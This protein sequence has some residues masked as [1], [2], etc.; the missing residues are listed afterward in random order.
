[1]NPRHDTEFF[2]QILDYLRQTR[3][4]DFTAYKRTSLMR[5]VLKRMQTVGVTSFE[6]YLD[7]L[8]VHQEEFAVLFNTILINVTSFFRDPEVWDYVDSTLVPMILQTRD[9]SEPLRVWSAGSA[10]GQEAYTMAMLL[11]ERLGIDGFRE[12]VKIYATDVDEEA[13]TQARQA[14]YQPRQ[15]EDVPQFLLEKYFDQVGADYAFSRDLRRAVIFGRH[16]L[17]QDA[18][19]S[20]VDVVLCRNTL[21]YFNSEAQSKILANLYFSVNPGGFLILGRA[22]MLFSHAAMFASVDLKRRVF[23]AVPKPNQRERLLILAQTGRDAM[24]SQTPDSFR[25]RDAAF[26]TDVIPQIVLDPNGIVVAV[27]LPV[28]QQFGIGEIDVGRP[29]QDLD[30]SYRPAELRAALRRALEE[31]REVMLKDIQWSTNGEVR[32]YDVAVAPLYE[33]DRSVLG[34]RITFADVTKFRTLQNELQHS[35]QELETAY[36]EL[37]STNE[38]LETTNEELQ[39]TVEELE[40]TNE[41]LQSTNE[42]LETMN[43][44]LQSTNEEL[45]TINDELRN[46]ST[47]LNAANSFLESVFTSLRS[48]VVVVDCDYRVQV[49]NDRAE[50]LWGVRASEAG[51]AHFISLDIGLPVSELRL[52]IR[53]VLGGN[54]DYV[55]LTL[56]ATNRRGKA[57][58]CHVG[59]SPLRRQEG[60]VEGAILMMEERSHA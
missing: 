41:E 44:E 43:E 50:D 45:Q 57:I 19:I 13:L 40:T 56:P 53:A 28:R 39:S 54:Q 3:G 21:M 1:M 6:Q 58:E 52:P 55:E 15:V 48:A 30:I 60:S 22:E 16:D 29:L 42:E 49:W 51:Q 26:E 2:E 37:Q 38:E 17:V 47:D 18:P 25:L 34:S 12:H 20:R 46:R 33:E 4:F 36:E 7:Y 8:Q 9:P 23:R 14:I 35:K 24:A 27:N 31:R 32:V 10:S 59:I 11:A 5:R